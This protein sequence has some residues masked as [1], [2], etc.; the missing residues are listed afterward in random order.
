MDARNS[1]K[2]SKL[3]KNATK[4]QQEIPAV[5]NGAVKLKRRKHKVSKVRGGEQ[6]SLNTKISDERLAAFGINPKKYR[7]KLKYKQNDTS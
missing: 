3:S 5:I 1:V 7:N 4:A 2:V 6:S